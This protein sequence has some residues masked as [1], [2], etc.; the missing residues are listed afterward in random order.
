MSDFSFTTIA[1]A[2]NGVVA[3]T[4]AA[5][6]AVV[7]DANNKTTNVV[8]VQPQIDDADAGIII[9]SAD[10]THANPTVT[11][12]DIVDA[13][14]TF[15]VADTAQTLT[16]KTLT[17]P[18]VASLYQDAGK[19]KLMTVPNTASDTLVTLAATQALTNKTLTAPKINE[20][21]TL[22]TTATELNVLDGIAR[23][24]VVLGGAVGTTVLDAK[25]S[26][27]ILVGDGTDLKS[28]VVGGD[29]TLGADG[30]LAL[31]VPKLS[32]INKTCAVAGFTDNLN[33]TG[34]IDFTSTLPAEAIPIGWKAVVGAGFAGDT[35]ATIQVGIDG[36]LDRFSADTTQSVFAAGTVGSFVIPA[37]V[38]KGI[39][40]VATPRVT[41][42]GTA[43][44]SSIVTE[45][46]GAMNVYLYYIITV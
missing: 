26:G 8:L 28:V 36:D 15:V 3:G 11:I 7:L 42:T 44:F 22:T 30:T 14:D 25:T 13:A 45:G 23:G 39:G 38:L 17:T 34:Y 21:V 37:D 2:L 33:T 6:K 12:P 16:N 31:A 24:S 19:T 43:D 20:N 41:I 35:T 46:N 5:N 27:Q 1:D 40:A 29:G 9:T 4:G 18:V 32:Y 10:Q